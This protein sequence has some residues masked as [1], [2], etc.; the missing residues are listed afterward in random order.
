MKRKDWERFVW[1]E[2]EDLVPD[3][4]GEVIPG[5][6]LKPDQTWVNDIHIFRI[7]WQLGERLVDRD[8]VKLQGESRMLSITLKDEEWNKLMEIV[9][10]I[11]GVINKDLSEGDVVSL[12]VSRFLDG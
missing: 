11:K 7:V 10:T 1:I 6:V 4:N 9:K 2:G 5:G 12:I 8:K 3:E